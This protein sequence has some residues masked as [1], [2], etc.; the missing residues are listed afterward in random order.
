MISEAG[1]A[2]CVRIGGD[3]GASW[4]G[5]FGDVLGAGW[6]ITIE[7]YLSAILVPE[8]EE[9]VGAVVVSRSEERTNCTRLR[10]MPEL[11]GRCCSGGR[12]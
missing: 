8:D 6:L 4:I 9:G 12:K 11:K 10:R 2:E 1:G 7:R 3:D 5:V